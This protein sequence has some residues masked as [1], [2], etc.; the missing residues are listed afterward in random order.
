MLNTYVKNYLESTSHYNPSSGRFVSE[1]PIGFSGIDMNLY[2]YAQNSPTKFVDPDGLL[3]RKEKDLI[4]R[5][6][7]NQ[8]ELRYLEKQ[9]ALKSKP[10]DKLTFLDKCFMSDLTVAEIRKEQDRINNLLSHLKNLLDNELKSNDNDGECK[11]KERSKD[12]INLGSAGLFFPGR[13]TSCENDRDF[14]DRVDGGV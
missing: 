5:I 12:V 14:W 1:D 13:S 7:K 6:N 4:R 2:R 10:K 9:L 8:R 11:E 3:T